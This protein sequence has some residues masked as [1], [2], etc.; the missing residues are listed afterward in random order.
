MTHLHPKAKNGTIPHA[1]I[2][3]T[4]I[5]KELLRVL[6]EITLSEIN[7]LLARD[8]LRQVVKDNH[9][10]FLKEV[11][12]VIHRHDPEGIYLGGA[13]EYESEAARIIPR[14]PVCLS[15]DDVWRVVCEEFSASG[16]TGEDSKYHTVAVE[17]ADLA[18]QRGYLAVE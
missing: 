2:A 13:D 14:L 1:A 15:L 12:A 18:K 4:P 8:A 17:L 9:G 6:P 5:E 3:M 11:A 7:E 16:F 10:E